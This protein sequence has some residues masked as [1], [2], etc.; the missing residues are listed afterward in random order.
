MC[1][2]DDHTAAIA[3]ISLR[4][5]LS[6][7]QNGAGDDLHSTATKRIRTA[8]EMVDAGSEKVR[9]IIGERVASYL[10]CAVAS[11]LFP[12]VLSGLIE[13]LLE[14]FWWM[15]PT[16]MSDSNNLLLLVRSG[17]HLRGSVGGVFLNFLFLLEKQTKMCIA[18]RWW[19]TVLCDSASHGLY[20]NTSVT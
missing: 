8:R 9:G 2:C 14:V 4:G 5:S 7:V 1:K 11:S 13:S 19:V 12:L 20:C 18:G 3:L 10:R 6:S 15:V 16:S 17:T